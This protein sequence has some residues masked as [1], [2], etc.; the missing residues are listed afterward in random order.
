[1]SSKFNSAL[2][3]WQ[4]DP[5]ILYLVIIPDF[6]EYFRMQT[7]TFVPLTDPKIEEWND[8][9]D[10]MNVPGLARDVPIQVC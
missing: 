4:N 7:W 2:F 5:T 6:F 1:M 3:S 10:S 8:Q 9:K